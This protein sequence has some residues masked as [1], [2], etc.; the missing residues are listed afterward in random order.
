[1]KLAMSCFALQSSASLTGSL[2][3]DSNNVVYWYPCGRNTRQILEKNILMPANLVDGAK[4]KGGVRFM[5]DPDL[6]H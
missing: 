4:K 6:K 3:I 1:M 5:Q 2:Q